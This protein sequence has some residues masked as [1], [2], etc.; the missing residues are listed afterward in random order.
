MGQ[1]TDTLWKSQPRTLLKH[2]VYR[3]YLHC[4][5]GKICQK[6][7]YSAIV[8]AFAGPGAYL[9]GPDGSPIVIA[10][11][12]LHHSRREKF[13]QLRLICLE[14]RNDRRDFLEGRLTALPQLPRLEVMVPPAG[15]VREYFRRLHAA[16]HRGNPGTP[17]LWILDPFNIS[18]AP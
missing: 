18:A 3:Q 4:W 11:T 16:A 8:D 6:F 7:K 17:V 14:E 15:N 1:P 2:Q 10:R 13:Q 9:D 5:R 12:F